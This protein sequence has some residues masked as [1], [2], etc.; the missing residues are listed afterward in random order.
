MVCDSL[1]AAPVVPR[2]RD[3]REPPEWAVVPGTTGNH[4][5]PRNHRNGGK[6]MKAGAP[7]CRLHAC[8][9]LC[10]GCTQA[11]P[12]AMTDPGGVGRV[13]T[14]VLSISGI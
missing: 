3:K 9:P 2:L 14:T 10:Q 7:A 6:P 11:V 8:S 1:S 4:R 13:V 5:Q 12:V